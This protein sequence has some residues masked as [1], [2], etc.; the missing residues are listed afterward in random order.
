[1]TDGEFRTARSFT[2]TIYVP[3]T[4]M[5]PT[6]SSTILVDGL[7]G[8]VWAVNS[9]AD[10]VTAIDT[11]T[12][13]KVFEKPVG[14]HPRTLALAP[15]TTLWV[16]NQDDATIS[17]LDSEDG[18]TLQTIPLPRASRPY[19]VA[20]S[21]DGA[22]AY[23]TLQGSG[24]LLKLDPIDG[25]MLATIDVG[26][27][28]RGLAI[29]GDSERILVTRFISSQDHGRVVEVSAAQF[30]GV[31]KHRLGLDP[32]PD[33]ETSGR[34][35]PNY[36][37]SIAIT[38]DGRRA[39]VPSKKD[40]TGRGLFRDGRPLT[41]DH[42]V[43]T[44]ISQI[45]LGSNDEIPRSRLDLD[46][47]DMA[48]A[49][50]FSELGD[51]AFVAIQGNNCVAVLDAYTGQKI[52]ECDSA[53][54]APQGLVLSADGQRLFLQNFLGRSV[55][56][57]DVSGIVNATDGT[58]KR[59][60]VIPT[61]S[62]ETLPAQV[63]K[64]KEI[65]YNAGD[66]R[67]SRGG[68]LSCASCHLDGEQDGRIWDFTDRGEG[69]RNTVTLLGRRGT[70]HGKLHWTGNFDEIQDFEQ[71]IRQSFGGLGFMSDAE[72]H[73][74]SRDTPLGDRKA[75]VSPDL[76]ALAAYV[77][78][79][80]HVNPSP[81]RNADGT[82]T[83]SAREGRQIFRQLNCAACHSGNEFTDSATGDDHDIDTIRPHTGKR[84]G[85]TIAGL[86]TP[87][88]KG[89]WE[90]APYLHDGSAT[91]LMDVITTANLNDM[92]G[93]T[94][95]LTDKQRQQLV[96]YLLQIDESEAVTTAGTNAVPALRR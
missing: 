38:P 31:R 84:L 45:D 20:F 3:P 80:D 46:E 52:Q 22:A 71:D 7:R 16:V 81:F 65:F 2:Q 8:R 91:T 40:N 60:R 92:H 35:V 77:T 69:L 53:G 74:G 90:T 37:S 19:G 62:H 76:D 6:A 33:T 23:V 18:A 29:T 28:P 10:T 83:T 67:M 66:P 44:I 14:R 88:L 15:D 11:A 51:F 82:L 61:V 86:D 36:L 42:T 41:F 27:N 34:G 24:R 57:Y 95:G 43:R 96:D 58:V 64:G 48:D 13:S 78:S 73:Q 85:Q 1:M 63:L 9:D 32:G 59:L 25:E 79:L 30:N 75:G 49:I 21:R 26:P 89:L 47:R 87:T 4:T 17:V 93:R 50:C 94:S 68:Y 39:W 5:R 72:F 56:V 70:A 55:T 54:A 12:L